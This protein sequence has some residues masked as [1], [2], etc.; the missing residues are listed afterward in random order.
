MSGTTTANKR[1]RE[2]FKSQNPEG[3]KE[4]F[5]LACQKYRKGHKKDVRVARANYY[6]KNIAEYLL[7]RSK[8]TA[9]R[10]SMSFNLTLAWVKKNL[11]SGCCAITYIPFDFTL[12]TNNVHNSFAPSIDRIDNE[13]GYT[14]ANCQ[15][16]SQ[17]YN[18]AK[19][20]SPQED[21]MKMARALVAL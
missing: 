17:I 9:K 15:I 11:E 18:R 12:G 14:K 5:K 1:W 2:K 21:V 19:G 8:F 4:Y 6:K 7:R 10:K 16:V 20:C 3:Y 13:K